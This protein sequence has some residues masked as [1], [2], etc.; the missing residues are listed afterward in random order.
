MYNVPILLIIFKR[1][2]VVLKTLESIKAVRP[3]KLYIAGD[4]ARNFISGEK[5]KV[6]IKGYEAVG[7]RCGAFRQGAC[8]FYRQSKLYA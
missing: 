6:H 8:T 7:D 4:G 2:E 5:E 3:T 1:K